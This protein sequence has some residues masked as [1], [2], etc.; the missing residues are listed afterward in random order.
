[1]HKWRAATNALIAFMYVRNHWCYRLT[2]RTI[3]CYTSGQLGGRKI[4]GFNRPK[5]WQVSLSRRYRQLS[6]H[7]PDFSYCI[8]FNWLGS[9]PCRK[10]AFNVVNYSFDGLD[11][12]LMSHVELVL[13][14]W[15]NL[16]WCSLYIR[17]YPP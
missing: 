16:D 17:L 4:L 12:A 15:S 5:P 9:L 8:V 7:G 6:S 2:V 3:R 1:M 11:D 10:Y 14:H 13:E